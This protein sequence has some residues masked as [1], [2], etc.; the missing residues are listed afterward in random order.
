MEAARDQDFPQPTQERG[1]RQGD[2]ERFKCDTSV[3]VGGGQPDRSLVLEKYN[4]CLNEKNER[5]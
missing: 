4:E 1:G 3:W 2:R 5:R